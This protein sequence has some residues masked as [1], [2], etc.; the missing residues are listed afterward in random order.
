[1]RAVVIA[2]ALLGSGAG[3]GYLLGAT[4]TR[5]AVTSR[6]PAPAERA[7]VVISDRGVS[8]AVLHRIVRAELDAAPLR[9]CEP[10]TP[11][12][13]PAPPV[14][15]APFDDGMRHVDQALARH[16]WT[17]ADASALARVLDAVSPEQRSQI[18]STLT[19]ALNR[20]QIKLTYQ[21]PLF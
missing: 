3:G 1:M 7:P 5:P 11:A 2:A 12:P 20:G 10:V 4:R 16:A 19:P 6:E 14:E 18:L 8:E 9:T 13:A 15:T 21:G 17:P